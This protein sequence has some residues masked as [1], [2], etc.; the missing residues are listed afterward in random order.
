VTAVRS[1]GLAQD[2]FA[3]VMADEAIDPENQYILQALLLGLLGAMR[4]ELAEFALSQL[5]GQRTISDEIQSDSATRPFWY[6]R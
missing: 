1:A 6:F 2:V 5:G 4:H 3:Q